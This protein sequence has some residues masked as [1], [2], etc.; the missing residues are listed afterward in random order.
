VVEKSKFSVVV[1]IMVVPAE[2]VQPDAT[3]RQRH[4]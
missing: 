1:E 3:A 4:P 2:S